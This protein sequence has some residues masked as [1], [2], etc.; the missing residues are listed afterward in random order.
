M[1]SALSA[2]CL[3]F[4]VWFTGLPCSGKTTLARALGTRLLEMGVLVEILDGDAVRENLSKGLGFS[5]ED[6]DAN[7]RRIA[8]V[9]NLL[10]RNGVPNIVAAVSPYRSARAEARARSSAF[11]EVYVE[12]PL[13]VCEARD[14][15]GMYAKARVGTL[16]HFTGVGDPYEPPLQP[17]LIIRSH[18]E[19]VAEATVRIIAEAQRLR[20]LR[21]SL[22]DP[23]ALDSRLLRRR[24]E[25]GLE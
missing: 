9:A 18:L 13:E 6:R 19:S 11:I 23:E 12:C 8:F 25:L 17:E 20:F 4:T 3:G 24:R 15:K 16:P 22:P 7:V 5:R 14:V 1:T 2:G 10:A 21:P